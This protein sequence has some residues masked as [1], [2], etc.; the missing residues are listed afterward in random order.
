MKTSSPKRQQQL[1]YNIAMLT[2]YRNKMLREAEKALV[3]INANKE[4][5]SNLEKGE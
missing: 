2:R 3:E 4:E 1:S 5:L